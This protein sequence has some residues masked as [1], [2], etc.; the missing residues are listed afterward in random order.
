MKKPDLTPGEMTK[1]RKNFY[2]FNLYNVISFSLLSGNIITLY[3]L[4]LG[5]G[6]FLVGLLSSFVFLGSLFILIGRLLVAKFGM[7]KLMGR[8]WIIRYLMMIPLL[9]APLLS[10]VGLQATIPILLTASVF[11]FQVSRG[12]A[13]TSYN[14]IIGSL[15]SEKTRGSFLAMVRIIEHVTILAMGIGMALLLGGSAPLYIYSLFFLIGILS[16]IIGA[17]FILK[18]PEPR[19]SPESLTEKLIKNLAKSFKE[20]TLRKFM[21]NNFLIT[22]LTAMIT[23][24]LIVYMKRVYSQP[25]SSIVFFTVFGSLG[26]IFMALISGFLID[27]LGAKPLYFY[28]T[29]VLTLILLPPAFSPVLTKPLGIWIFSALIF[30]FQNMG[31]FGTINSGQVYFLAAIKAEQRLN[32]GIIYLLS[33]GLAGATGS[34]LGGVIL[35]W[36]QIVLDNRMTDVFRIYFGSIALFF[37]IVLFMVNKMESLGAYSIRHTMSVIFSPRDLRAIGL[38]NRLGKAKSEKQEKDTIRAM[39]ESGSPITTEEILT[40][41]NSPRFTIRAE[42]LNALYRLPLDEHAVRALIS[43]VKNHA[44]TTAYIAADILGA[45]KINQGIKILRKQLHSRDFFLGG[46]CMVALAKLDDRESIPLIEEIVAETSNSRLIIHGASALEIY[47]SISSI[48][49]LLT[50]LEKKTS[51]FLRDEIILSI[52]GILSMAEWFYPIYTSFLEKSSEG[53]SLLIDAISQSVLED[54]RRS[55]LNDLAYSIPV[56]DRELFEKTARTLIEILP[57]K[58]NN[59]SAVII[60]ALENEQLKELD[61]L[62]FLVAAVIIRLHTS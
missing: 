20:A 53:I 36:L 15:S 9:A 51:P 12:I 23:P 57:V 45:K 49:I 11:G 16:G 7:V 35:V 28:F 39:A 52:A 21:V 33:R 1:A 56:K 40:R 13:I 61:R 27:K 29:G 14:P 10:L 19:Q 8:F 62:Y 6:N 55:E 50:K 59:I 2:F 54:A 25:D 48:P 22:M 18:L 43:D 41:L 32:L 42:A 60:G 38:L 30:F 46:K 24:F 37:T 5:A 3:A 31:K 4:K 34:L 17:R 44:F 58:E 47:R 26:A